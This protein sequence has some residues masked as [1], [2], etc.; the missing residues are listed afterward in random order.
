[1]EAVIL[2]GA[3]GSGKSTFYRQHFVDSH[4][5][6]NLDMLRTRHRERVLLRAC[7]SARIAFVV[8]NTNVMASERAAYIR[9]ALEQGFEVKGYLFTAPLADCLERNAAREGAAR[10]PDA[11]VRGRHG[12]LELPSFAEGFSALSSVCIQREG[13]FAVSPWS[14]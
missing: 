7:L 12:A 1:M 8:D 4:V 6:I 14:R 10:I 11:G 13:A 9:P 5:R 3:P 2:I